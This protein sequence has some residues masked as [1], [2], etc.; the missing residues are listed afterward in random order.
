MDIFTIQHERFLIYGVLRRDL[1]MVLLQFS[2][3]I[4][5]I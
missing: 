4:E 3:G 2:G 1:V 5:V